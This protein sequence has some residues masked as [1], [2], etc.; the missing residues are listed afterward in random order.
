[1]TIFITG[2]R[3]FLGSN[4]SKILSPHYNI[5]GITSGKS[6]LT[7]SIKTYNLNDLSDLNEKPELIVLCHAAV[8]SGTDKITDE[9]LFEGNVLFTKRIIEKYPESKLIYVS[10]VSIFEQTQETIT[11][12]TISSPK[13]EYAISKLW[14]EQ[15]IKTQKKNVI[16]RLPSI[17]GIGMK[18]NTLIPNYIQ[19]ALDQ[20][21]INVWGNG[22]R[23]QNYIHVFDAAKLIKSIIENS[24]FENDF[25]L[26]SFVGE[27]SNIEIAT[28]ISNETGAEI[29]YSGIDE[30]VSF[31]Y[32]NTYTR[33][34][35]NW[36][37][38]KNI[39]DEIIDYIKWKRKQF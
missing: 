30:S 18:E 24:N 27:Y 3:G 20:R 8:S 22:K 2:I 37:P 38:E 16:V 32:D 26:G 33:N 39:K 15:L 4:L 7:G 14:A 35:L 6:D 5:T 1:M 19:Q 36:N 25:F 28:I 12:K 34:K 17:Y 13:T 11:E 10:S 21:R 23:L 31:K 9:I 29:N